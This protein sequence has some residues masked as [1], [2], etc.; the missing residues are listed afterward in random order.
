M[1]EQMSRPRLLC[2]AFLTLALT[3]LYNHAH[4][5]ASSPPPQ[6]PNSLTVNEGRIDPLGFH[7]PTP[8]FS[9]KL[10][11][12]RSGAHQTAYQIQAFK[13]DASKN[14]LLWDSGKVQSDQSVYVEYKG[15]TLKSRENISWKVRYWDQF[16]EAS[17][18]S[19]SSVIEM[20]LLEKSDWKASWIHQDPSDFKAGNNGNPAVYLRKTF[21][22]KSIPES[23]RL[24]LT[25]KGV[26]DFRINGQPVSGD[27]F[28][29]GWTNYN[30]RIDVYTYDV[31]SLLVQGENIL[32]ASIADGW[33]AGT[34]SD[35]FY[36]KYPELLAQLEIR[37]KE[38]K[39]S[40]R[41][42]T[43]DSWSYTIQGPITL[44]DI[45]HG[46]DYDARKE[47]VDWDT[48]SSAG[49]DLFSPVKTAPLD[50]GV[51]LSP[52]PFRN[53]RSIESLPSKSFHHT[54][55][56][57]LV[58][59]VG[60]NMAGW[61]H[62]KVPGKEGQKITIRMAEMLNDDGT[63]YR[64]SYRTAR[65]MATYI[66][67][68]D[69]TVDY[70]QTFTFFGFRYVEISGYD[71]TEEPQ[72]SW[73]TGE[74]LHTDFPRTGTFQSSNSKLNQLYQ[75]IVWGQKGNFLDIPTDCPQ[76]DERWGWTGDAQVFAPTALF[77][78]DSHAFL[79]SYLDTMRSE[80]GE[81]GSIPSVVPKA[82]LDIFGNSAGW[83]DAAFIMPWELYVRTGDIS[84]LKEFYPMMVRHFD[85]YDRKAIDGLVDEPKSFADW[86][87]PKRYGTETVGWDERSGET[88]TYLIAS[89]YYGLGASILQKSA[90]ILGKPEDSDRFS[91]AY[92]KTSESIKSKFF[93]ENGRVIEGTET[94]TAYLLP[95]AFDL[96]DPKFSQKVAAR[97]SERIERDQ[98][99]LNTG[100][101][102]TSVLIST[103]EKYGLLDQAVSILFSDR[104]PS[105]FYSIDQGATTIWERWNSYSKEDGFGDA[106]M[107]SFNHYAYGA[108]GSFLFERIAGIAPTERSPGYK[109]VVI[110]PILNDL[111]PLKSANA[112][113]DSRYGEIESSWERTLEGWIVTV[114]IPPNSSGK[115]KIPTKPTSISKITG[116]LL[117]TSTDYGSEANA[118]AGTYKF[119]VAENAIEPQVENR[120]TN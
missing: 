57:T 1:V 8:V 12:D 19:N 68:Q 39:V 35:R 58:Y 54:D 38:G 22:I 119:L 33:Y 18:W 29:P 64:D 61:I 118:T 11:D 113:L 100:F 97:L 60:Q 21:N 52:K 69:G 67:K 87:Q 2:I 106:S 73:V 101:L 114:V 90:A 20:G 34:I 26:V 75:N 43:D 96:L 16:N 107:N 74:V 37:T 109:Q 15:P 77:N 5:M 108:V 111:I 117:F 40:Q 105:W 92:S 51:K 55:E 95:L 72:L 80:M 82:H 30:Q 104:Y 65:S 88:S 71:S 50:T 48:S 63:L 4:S 9:W 59:D 31:T 98:N 17:N 36:G 112:T 66:P 13:K 70:T 102:G 83:G 103:L 116:E 24:Y 25:A 14:L 45:Y 44:A 85:Y 53:V 84:V 81:D 62:I 32:A 7:D 3:S 23:A 27:A 89:S 115:I 86:L 41:I 110:Q 47:I 91:A 79:A 120:R 6:P 56:E 46:E 99:R 78:F 76:R 93:D 49:K 42:V 10:Q 28:I 94:Q